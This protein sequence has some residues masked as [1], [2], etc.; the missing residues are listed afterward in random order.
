MCVKRL[1]PLKKSYCLSRS[2]LG[3]F[4]TLLTHGGFPECQILLLHF[5]GV[6]GRKMDNWALEFLCT[7][8][9]DSNTDVTNPSLLLSS[10]VYSATS[11]CLLFA[12]AAMT[13]S[14]GLVESRS[15]HLMTQ[16]PDLSS[17]GM[18]N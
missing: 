10:Y 3:V 14:L 1:E 17:K 6:T 7:I 15:R 9:S 5:A 11:L 8:W 2:F 4:L 13:F 12:G 16:A 18:E